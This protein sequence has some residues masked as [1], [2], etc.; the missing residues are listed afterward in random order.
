MRRI[1]L[2][3]ILGVV[4]GVG[5]AFIP[6]T[7]PSAAPQP[8]MRP[9]VT[10]TEENQAGTT[11][12]TSNPTAPTLELIFLGLLAGLLVATPLFLVARKR[13]Q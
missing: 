6:S 12:P 4:L 10:A 13:V 11:L 8:M 1:W 9:L 3:A 7:G 5:V 2:A